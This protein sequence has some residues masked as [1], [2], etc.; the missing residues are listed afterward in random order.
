[1]GNRRMASWR[2]P[3]LPLPFSCRSCFQRRHETVSTCKRHR[4]PLSPS[5][6][7]YRALVSAVSSVAPQLAAA[8]VFCFAFQ[9][10]S[11]AYTSRWILT[12]APAPK[13]PQRG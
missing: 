7:K 4:K 3:S 1:M 10:A 5:H 9:S 12:D 8:L 6:L 11:P 2:L 13:P